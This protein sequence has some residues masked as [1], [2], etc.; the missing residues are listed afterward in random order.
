[1]MN[2]SLIVLSDHPIAMHSED[3]FSAESSP[4]PCGLYIR[5]VKQE[6]D[7]SFVIY[8]SEHSQHFQ[9]VDVVLLDRGCY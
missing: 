5:A 8:L 4:Y 1:M 2:H 3:V 9:A 7:I 6:A